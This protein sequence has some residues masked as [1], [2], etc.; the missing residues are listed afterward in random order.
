MFQVQHHRH[1]SLAARVLLLVMLM[2]TNV[3]QVGTGMDGAGGTAAAKESRKRKSGAKTKKAAAEAS[4]EGGEESV[5]QQ[6][7]QGRAAGQLVLNKVNV[8]CLA[9]G[10]ERRFAAVTKSA[11]CIDSL[12]SE[13]IELTISLCKLSPPPASRTGY[14]L[15]SNVPA[16]TRL[17][18]QE[19]CLHP[20][21]GQDICVQASNLTDKPIALGAGVCLGWLIVATP[22]C[23]SP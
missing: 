3:A 6:Q 4:A 23:E 5:E 11:C 14:S 15:I 22:P 2:T 10:V 1:G 16:A 18:L 19:G 13:A 12:S 21:A 9:A 8:A 17:F 7:Q 20:V